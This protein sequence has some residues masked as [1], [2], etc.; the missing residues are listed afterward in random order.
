MTLVAWR[1]ES[2]AKEHFEARDRERKIVPDAFVILRSGDAEYRAFVEI[3][4]GSM[5]MLRLGH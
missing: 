2:E 1:R 3:D 4:M 5:S